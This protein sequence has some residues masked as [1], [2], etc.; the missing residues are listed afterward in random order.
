[1]S[2]LTNGCNFRAENAT[3]HKEHFL[4][5][6]KDI[7]LYQ[8]VLGVFWKPIVKHY[9]ENKEWL[10]VEAILNK[11]LSHVL[12]RIYPIDYKEAIRYWSYGAEN[13]DEATEE[14]VING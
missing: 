1:L 9:V 10:S 12:P 14:A 4:G 2:F 11:R 6:P 13:E 3:E 8:K 5:H 7:I